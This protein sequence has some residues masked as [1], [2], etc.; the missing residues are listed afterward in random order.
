[1]KFIHKFHF[2]C[3]FL[4]YPTTRFR[5]I[6]EG[7]PRVQDRESCTLTRYSVPLSMNSNV[8]L[9]FDDCSTSVEFL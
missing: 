5:P 9:L 1:M 3:F 6:V 8:Y 2:R 4:G 7:F